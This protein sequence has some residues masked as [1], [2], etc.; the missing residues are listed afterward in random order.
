MVYLRPGC[1]LRF[2]AGGHQDSAPRHMGEHIL[3]KYSCVKSAGLKTA[4]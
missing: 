3:N 1:S 2:V 4:G